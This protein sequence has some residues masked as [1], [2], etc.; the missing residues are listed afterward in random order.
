MGQPQ[1]L[2]NDFDPAIPLADERY[3]RFAR[4]RVMGIPA[5]TAAWEAGFRAKGDQPVLPGN[6]ARYD[7]HPA[8]R[9]RKKHLAG[10]ETEIVRDLRNMV[11]E[12]LVRAATLDVLKRFAVVDETGKITKIDFAAWKASEHSAS[13]TRLKFDPDSGNVVDVEWEKPEDARTQIR[14]M[15]GFR[16]A[17]KNEHAG[18]DG[19]AIP[20]HIDSLTTPQL[21][22]L[23][24]RIRSS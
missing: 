3:E 12:G 14:D 8:V 22:H 16:A 1:K 17:R 4:F 15:Y 18:K 24:E 5:E 10:D 7:R 23:I 2:A 9:A 20:I 6:V 11:R 19:A 21:D 13:L